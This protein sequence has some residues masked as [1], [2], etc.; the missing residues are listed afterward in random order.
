MSILFIHSMGGWP[1][2]IFGLFYLVIWVYCLVDILKSN[3]KDPNM[4]LI[5][6]IILLFA[7]VIGALVYLAI[8][9]ST[10][11]NL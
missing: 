6:I 10:K 11:A 8:G 3:F 2:L 7:Q 4:K 1:F 5:W 9:K